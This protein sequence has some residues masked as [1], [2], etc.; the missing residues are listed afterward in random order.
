[1]ISLD[2]KMALDSH[3]HLFPFIMLGLGQCIREDGVIYE[4]DW[5]DNIALF[6]S[7]GVDAIAY[8]G[9]QKAYETIPEV[10]EYLD[11]PENKS[12]KYDWFGQALSAEVKYDKQFKAAMELSALWS[13]HGIRAVV[14]K[15]FAYAR[16]YPVPQHRYCSDLDCFLFDRICHCF[17]PIDIFR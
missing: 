14:M 12:L 6:G 1:M 7:Q 2:F 13:S 17:N 9:L 3:M 10:A 5:K 8:D 16:F 4:Y 11:K 15:G